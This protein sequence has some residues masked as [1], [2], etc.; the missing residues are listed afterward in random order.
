MNTEDIAPSRLEKAKREIRSLI[1]RLKGDRVG[2]VAFAGTAILY[3]PL[4]LDYGAANLFLDLLDTSVI[5]DPGTALAPAIQAATSAFSATE[6][7]Y[8][9][10]VL[11][12]D[13]EDLEGDIPAAVDKARDGGVIIYTVGI[14]TPEG[15]PIPVRDEKGDIVEYRKDAGGQIVVSRLDERALAQIA[16]IPVDATFEPVLLRTNW[17]PSMTKSPNRR[18]RNLNQDCFRI[19]RIGSNTHWPSR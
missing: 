13:G 9:I 11:F 4:T 10:L 14:G 16:G 2:L 12:T 3:C 1:G 6:R 19:L 17:T 18:K 7:K 8:K 15:K 5:P